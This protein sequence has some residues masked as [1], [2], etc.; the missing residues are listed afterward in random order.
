MPQAIPRSPTMFIAPRRV[1]DSSPKSTPRQSR[2]QLTWTT[3]SPREPPT[4]I[5]SPRCLQ[6]SRACHRIGR[7]RQFLPRLTA[8]PRASIMARSSAGY[9]VSPRGRS[10]P[11]RLNPQHVRD[12]QPKRQARASP[13][14][15][16]GA[17]VCRSSSL[18]QGRP[19]WKS[20]WKKGR[21]FL[22]QNE[23]MGLVRT[24]ACRGIFL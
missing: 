21:S 14:T 3:G 23:L 11:Q 16:G 13:G 22:P 20:L 12:D 6:D 5:R 15:C 18:G 2:L 10:E 4:A 1:V 8:K 17:R 9:A 24:T 7:S 19:Q